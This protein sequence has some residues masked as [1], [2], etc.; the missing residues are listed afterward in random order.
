[1]VVRMVCFGAFVDFELLNDG[2]A[3]AAH[4]DDDEVALVALIAV[5]AVTALTD[6]ELLGDVGVAVVPFVGEELLEGVER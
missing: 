3:V 5:V 4:V 1:M 6:F 2:G